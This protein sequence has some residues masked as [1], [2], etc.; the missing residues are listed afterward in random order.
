VRSARQA[1]SN[2]LEGSDDLLN[3]QTG[4]QYVASP[5]LFLGWNPYA[6]LCSLQRISAE[7]PLR[8]ENWT[9]QSLLVQLRTREFADR[10]AFD[11]VRSWAEIEARLRQQTEWHVAQLTR[12][13]Q[14]FRCK[15]ANLYRDDMRR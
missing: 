11:N 2:F 6:P 1:A 4:W 3:V 12:I 14:A 10:A 5:E 8:D 13:E 15:C 7:L 9:L